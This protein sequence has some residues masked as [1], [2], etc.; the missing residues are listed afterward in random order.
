M[1]FSYKDRFGEETS[2]IENTDA[3]L[4][5]KLRGEDFQG[6]SFEFLTTFTPGA[7]TKFDLYSDGCLSNCEFLISKA[8][9]IITKDEFIPGELILYFKLGNAKPNDVDELD[10]MQFH[11]QLNYDEHSYKTKDFSLEK[12]QDIESALFFLKDMLPEGHTIKSCFFCMYSIYSPYGK[13]FFNDMQC[14]RNLKGIYGS[15]E[16]LYESGFFHNHEHEKYVSELDVC[17]DYRIKP[18]FMENRRTDDKKQE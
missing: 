4:K 15:A 9:T 17:T 10:D 1:R 8:I 13:N 5:V 18:A 16:K 3:T 11:L 2:V 7:N 6:H 14:Y 12:G